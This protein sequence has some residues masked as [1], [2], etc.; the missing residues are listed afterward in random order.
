MNF[1]AHAYLSFGQEEILVGNLVAD[2]IKGKDLQQFSVD[3]QTGI[4]LHREIDSFTDAHPLV[5]AGQSYL[6]PKFRHYSSVITDIFFDYFLA[7]NWNKY[8]S[9]SLEEFASHAYFIVEK[10]LPDLP[11]RFGE[12]FYW[13][14]SQ[15]WL[16]HYRELEGIQRTLNGMTR[17]AKFDSKMNEST[18][19]LREK[20]AE[21]EVIFFA[22]FRDLETFAKAKLQ[23]IQHL[24]GRH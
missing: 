9:T 18:S 15:N 11:L 5:K 24:H 23:E 20:E 4:L 22:F 14:K 21:F 1:L 3:I 12:M 7:K 8:S 16:L 13:M 17:R 10:H 19:L 6:R 2:F